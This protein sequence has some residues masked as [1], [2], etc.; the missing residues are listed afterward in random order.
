MKKGLNVGAITQ[1]AFDEYIKSYI[2][3]KE[4]DTPIKTCNTVIEKSLPLTIINPQV[5][6]QTAYFYSKRAEL[7]FHKGDYRGAI[8]DSN[9]AENLSN[10]FSLSISIE[11]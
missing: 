5:K 6:P 10:A 11:G 1:G 4:Y 3:T 8:A 7:K 2:D 9:E